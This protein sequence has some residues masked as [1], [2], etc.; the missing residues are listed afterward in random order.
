MVKEVLRDALRRYTHAEQFRVE[1]PK[2]KKVSTIAAANCA[3]R[4]EKDEG[5]AAVRVRALRARPAAF[6]TV[7]AAVAAARAGAAVG[8]RAWIV[9]HVSTCVRGGISRF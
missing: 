6:D 9:P 3:D 7:E 8:A 2:C 4:L 1:C 5:L